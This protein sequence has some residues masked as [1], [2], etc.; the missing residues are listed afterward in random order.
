M[1]ELSKEDRA[2]IRGVVDVKERQY[3]VAIDKYAQAD[4]CYPAIPTA[5]GKAEAELEA[6]KSIPPST[7]STLGKTRKQ[8]AEKHKAW[9]RELAEVEVVGEKGLFTALDFQER[10]CVA[11]LG[12]L[13]T[14]PLEKIIEVIKNPLNF[15]LDVFTV[16]ALAQAHWGKLGTLLHRSSAFDSLLSDMEAREEEIKTREEIVRRN[17]EAG[18]LR[19]RPGGTIKLPKNDDAGGDSWDPRF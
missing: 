12:D 8:T 11:V 18:Q 15:G 10:S 3:S 14:G 4:V 1:D 7:R 5:L 6:R 19:R 9:E 13:D 16:D 2:K 17:I